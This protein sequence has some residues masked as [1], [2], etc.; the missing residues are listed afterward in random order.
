MLRHDL[1]LNSPRHNFF[2]EGDGELGVPVYCY[3][4]SSFS[5]CTLR[6]FNQFFLSTISF[7]TDEG[8][9]RKTKH[10]SSSR[11]YTYTHLHVHTQTYTLLAYSALSA[12]HSALQQ[13]LHGLVI[14]E[15][16]QVRERKHSRSLWAQHTH[17][18]THIEHTTL[19]VGYLSPSC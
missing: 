11:K 13:Y 10:W 16:T 19:R 4:S 1:R 18:H 6:F 15:R 7:R 14:K 12:G 17:T 9:K 2:L 3:P 8:R 5:F